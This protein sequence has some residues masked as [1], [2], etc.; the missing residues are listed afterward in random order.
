MSMWNNYF[1]LNKSEKGSYQFNLTDQN[2]HN[3]VY[4]LYTFYT[5]KTKF[6][7]EVYKICLVLQT[8]KAKTQDKYVSSKTCTGT[9]WKISKTA[10]IELTQTQFWE[11]QGSGGE[12]SCYAPRWFPL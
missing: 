12:S 11:V 7:E 2:N 1:H 5:S 4:A 3:F 9:C 8:I 10:E 6:S